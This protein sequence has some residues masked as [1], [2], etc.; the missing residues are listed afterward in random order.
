MRLSREVKQMNMSLL[1]QEME[2]QK[3]NVDALA[4]KTGINRSALYRRFKTGGDKITVSEA[5]RSKEALCLERD[6]AIA[7]FLPE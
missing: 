3:V 4:E 6:V 7:I 2:R 1:R 5:K